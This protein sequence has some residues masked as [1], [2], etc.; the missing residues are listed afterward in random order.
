[1]LYQ[2]V[3]TV[4]KSLFFA[5]KAGFFVDL[6]IAAAVI[7]FLAAGVYETSSQALQLFSLSV[8]ASGPAKSAPSQAGLDASRPLASN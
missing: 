1:M 4:K 6:A 2:G 3:D 5:R 8:S 7:A